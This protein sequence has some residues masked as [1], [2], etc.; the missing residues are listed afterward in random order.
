M[1]FSEQLNHYIEFLNCTSKELSNTSKLSEGTLSRYRNGMRIP[2]YQST[3][4]TDIAHGLFQ[5]AQIKNIDISE[6]EIT[7]KLNQS[8]GSSEAIDFE[9]FS[10]HLKQ[11]MST[12][13]IT[14]K[15]IA[16]GISYD[17]STLSRILHSNKR[18]AKLSKIVNLITTYFSQINYTEDQKSKLCE[19]LET[20]KTIFN[21]STNLHDKLF[22]YFSAKS[23]VTVPAP[24]S[25]F[26]GGFLQK[27]DDFNLEDYTR[28][29]NFN[30]IKIPTV[31][32]QLPKEKKYIG[33]GA[34]KE[35]EL[36]F[37]KATVLSNSK[38]S[39]INYSDMP[40]EEMVKDIDFYKKYMLGLAMMIKKGLHIHF[41]HDTSRPFNEMMVGLEGFIPLYM[42][43]QISPY[44]L[45]NSQSEIFHHLIKVSGAAALSG[46]AISEHYED[47]IYYLTTKK[48]TVSCY[49]KTAEQ[50]LQKSLPLMEIYTKEHSNEF[51]KYIKSMYSISGSRKLIF[52]CLPFFTISGELLN[53][54]L[55][56]N[57]VNEETAASIKNFVCSEKQRVISLLEKEKITFII[58]KLTK[59]DF[60]KNVP[61][62]SLPALFL[63]CSIPYTFEIYQNHFSQT[64]DFVNQYDKCELI[65]NDYMKF[66]NIDI[67]IIKD[68]QVLVSK[69]KTPT[70]HFVIK[71]PRMV[72]S[73]DIFS[74]TTDN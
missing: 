16:A 58:P 52:S 51:M 69:V 46:E 11:L 26:I 6:T 74:I 8:L 66:K 61:S 31:P 19:I 7:N 59:E 36:G 9:I 68:K 35:S 27:L 57:S 39:V 54:L 22:L 37:I 5:I 67:T 56:H 64:K 42:T 12:L 50:L 13:N 28:T 29:I 1:N 25:D 32:F 14:N 4:I 41:I 21:N 30:D 72:K 55:T 49:R 15:E 24:C 23:E 38:D 34:I 62:L 47:A 70:I 53:K 2:K 3:Q 18:P 63:D 71:H 40:I 20:D 60:E 65:A 48:D 17:P 73:F 45:K 44:Y 10:A 43:G 33:L